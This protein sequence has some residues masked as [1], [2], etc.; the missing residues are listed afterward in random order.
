MIWRID[1]KVVLEQKRMHLR[2]STGLFGGQIWEL[3]E[4]R[5][6]SILGFLR[7]VLEGRFSAWLGGFED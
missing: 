6:G 5:T 3:F 7:G 1:L 2:V 4:A